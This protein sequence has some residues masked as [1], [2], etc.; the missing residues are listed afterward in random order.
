MT[1]NKT[2]EGRT[3]AGISIYTY[4]Y[5]LKVLDKAQ[6]MGLVLNVRE[7]GYYI[8]NSLDVLTG[9]SIPTEIIKQI[10]IDRK[11]KTVNYIDTKKQV[12]GLG[13]Y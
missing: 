5:L 6:H 7:I 4:H 1:I 10:K 13:A 11:M 3:N 12:L 9:K 2:I 8:L